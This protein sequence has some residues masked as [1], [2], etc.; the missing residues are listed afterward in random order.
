MGGKFS[1]L[2]NPDTSTVEFEIV[3]RPNGMGMK[4]WR[5]TYAVNLWNE[6]YV[7]ATVDGAA[8]ATAA[9]QADRAAHLFK[10][11]WEGSTFLHN[12]EQAA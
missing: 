5:N 2:V 8:P 4:G 1:T 11:R 7:Q 6:V 3:P 12:V 9:A 10:Q